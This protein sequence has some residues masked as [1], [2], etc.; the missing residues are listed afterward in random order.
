MLHCILFCYCLTAFPLSCCFATIILLRQ[1]HVILILTY[2]L[3][4]FCDAVH[5][6]SLSSCFVSVVMLLFCFCYAALLL[7]CFLPLS[8]CSASGLLFCLSHTV[9]PQSCCFASVMLLCLC[10]TALPLSVILQCL[11]QLLL[12][13][14][15]PLSC[16]FAC[17]I[18]LHL[19]F[20]FDNIFKLAIV[21][22]LDL[23]LH[24]SFSCHP[25]SPLSF[26]HAI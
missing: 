3:L 5:S 9:L 4:R 17:I 25:A 10:H 18:G 1:F 24:P 16:F 2:I 7:S 12:S 8:C 11:N 26:C 15:F 23:T 14:C 6:L 19:W 22:Q 21:G 13:F 20:C